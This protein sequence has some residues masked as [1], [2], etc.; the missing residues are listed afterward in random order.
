MRSDERDGLEKEREAQRSQRWHEVEELSKCY[1]LG[2]VALSHESPDVH[3]NYKPHS[4][5]A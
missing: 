3:E 2:G 5:C 1:V 4:I